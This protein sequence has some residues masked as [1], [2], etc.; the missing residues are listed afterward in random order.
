MARGL[1]RESVV[2][3][4]L[5]VVDDPIP[6]H[7][8]FTGMLAIPFLDRDGKPLQLRFRCLEQHEH[9]DFHHGKYNSMAGDPVR[10]FNVGALH[11]A[12]DEIH[13]TEGEL[14]ALVL[15]QLGLPAVAIPGALLYRNHHRR[16]LAGF[17]TVWSWGDPDDAGAEL[18]QKIIRSLRQ[19]KAVSLRDGDVT[20]TFLKGGQS[21]I[22]ALIGKEEPPPW[23]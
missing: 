1:N 22:F 10:M 3:A 12:A 23:E 2:T 18:N 21:A 4:R 6:G 15:N 20:D 8:R 19:A 11:R 5:G 16:M 17:S 14:D 9:R 7:G 13:V